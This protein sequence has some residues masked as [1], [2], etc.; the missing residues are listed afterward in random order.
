M[1]SAAI[2]VDS[3]SVT[4]APTDLKADRTSDL[5][6]G[7]ATVLMVDFSIKYF[8]Y[9]NVE[10]IYCFSNFNFIPGCQQKWSISIS[11]Q[12]THSNNWHGHGAC[13]FFAVIVVRV[14]S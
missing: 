5:S 9:V 14:E 1:E 2:R 4:S 13:G 7:V 10:K 8:C 11:M 6:F 12:V 3:A